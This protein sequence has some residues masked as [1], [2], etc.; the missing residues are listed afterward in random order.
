MNNRTRRIFRA[1]CCTASA[2]L[3]VLAGVASADESEIFVGTGNAVSSQRPNILFIMDTS[4]S[5]DEDVETQVPFD[6]AVDFPGNA[7]CDDRIF[8]AQGSN[9]SDPPACT[10]ANSVPAANFKCDAGVQTMAV[11][12]FYVAQH[13]AQ[14]RANNAGVKRWR[15]INGSN[16]ADAWVECR[17]DAGAHG[18][19]VDGNKLWASNTDGPWSDDSAAE[20]GW[21]TN[22]A[23]GGYVFYTG[24]Y[25]NWLNSGGTITQKRIEI[26]QIVAKQTIDQL[27]VSDSV[28][29]ALMRFSNNTSNQCN[30]SSAEG[31]MVIQ[32]MGPVAAN[33]AAMKT[34]IDTL[35]DGSQPDGCTPLSETMYEAYLYLSGGAVDY[36]INSRKF[37]GSG[38][39][40]PSVAA[41]RQPGNQG[42]YS[43][44]LLESC[45]KNFI[46]LLTDGL[47]TA[48]NSADTE[49]EAL[50][51]AS[52]GASGNGRCL[53]EIAE[54]MYE[55][56]MRPSVPG[57]QDQNVTTYTIGF[58][59]EVNNSQILQNTAS[60]GGGVFYEASDTATLS[61]VLT[62]IVRT[63]LDQNTSFTAPAV[64]VN[65]FNRTQNLN[66]LYV[67]VFRPSETYF[68]DGNVKKYR[69]NPAGFIEDANNQPAVE[70]TTGFFRTTA[71]SFWSAGVD[72]DN[73]TLGG[74]A[75]ELPDPGNRNVYTDLNTTLALTSAANTVNTANAAITS[76][77]LGLAAAENPGRDALI[78]WLRG[79]DV[80][81]EDGDGSSADSRDSM[82][83]PMNGRPATVIY[84]GS[85]ANPDPN[86]GVVY[87]VTNEGYL[88]AIDAV[89]GSEL[90]AFVPSQLLARARDMYVNDAV[91]ERVYGLDG[92]VRVLRNEVNDNGVIESSLGERVMI[93]FGM[94]RGGGDYFGLDVTDRNV[95]TLLFRI[96]PNEIGAKLLKNAGQS[97]STPAVAKVNIGSS[98]QNSLQQVL[99]FGGGYD[100]VQDNGPYVVDAN[101]NQIFMVDAVS[102]DVLWY[103]G[104]TTDTTAD[105]RHA[106]LTHGIPADIRIFDITGDGFA[107]RMYAGDMGGRVWRF[108]IH[109]GQTRTDL[110]TGGVFA[111][112]GNAH[113]GVHPLS[114]TRR[115]YNA[116]D[117]AFLAD[118]GK[119]W[120]NIGIGSGYRGHPLNLDTQDR[121]YSL[122]DHL[123]FARLTQTQYDAATV[124]T[125]ADVNLI[126]I[127]SDIEPTIPPGATGWRLDLRRTA[128]G[129]TGEKALSEARTIESMI[130]FTT[131]EPHSDST[132][133]S[134]A[135]S[136]APGT[137]RLYS[138][139][140]FTG[141]PAFELE[142]SVDP[143]ADDDG[144]GIPNGAEDS[145]GDGF[146]NGSDPDDDGDGILDGDDPDSTE[147]R[148]SE[149]A[150][151][152]I[153]PE[154]VWLFPSPDDP[155]NCVGAECRPDPVCLVGLEN[156]GVSVNLAPVR[157]FWRQTGVN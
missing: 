42:M 19:G 49:I 107:D 89:D 82:G 133:N 113:L 63:I 27:A 125:E 66:D 55:N 146:P 44:P 29:L 79:A 78:N 10:N 9:S 121:F 137:N 2:S 38:G 110:V 77:T 32:E 124:I 120:L 157:T 95:P 115:F 135:C 53:E 93:Y 147:D 127:T 6:P 72:G 23:G 68:W 41:S 59:P 119:T 123:P 75:N 116:P 128:G 148:D 144:D 139:S 84:G 132:P 34:K 61:T 104:P 106:S 33:A 71:Q 151:S 37:P 14:W 3:C 100:T 56:D 92:N 155:E 108:D 80:S 105:L 46:V 103:A 134:N 94:R 43:S 57:L 129:W 87:A 136:P 67:T 22:G 150:Q 152:G 126:D 141:A 143:D 109:N 153:A 62:N 24:N 122:R 65:A 60:R 142:S 20:M 114:S 131:Y 1:L 140:A 45:Q 117:V 18:D 101:G 98:T 99:V 58:G 13:G 130:Q 156:C 25:I 8:Y 138:I 54:Y 88:H 17:I 86:D 35:D 21:N 64:S 83:D 76:A 96:G 40:E 149:L 12:G 5:M 26:M 73:V 16:V 145:D 7:N 90:W 36:G 74:A 70:V 85:T 15:N 4:G 48:D 118:G 50:F 31:G 69:L 28:N 112:L 111:S 39:E 97:W 47:P 81:D 30:N 11:S 52:C 154:V 91:T 51:G 102:G